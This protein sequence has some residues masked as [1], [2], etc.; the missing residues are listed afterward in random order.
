MN[1]CL[2]L[3]LVLL[4]FSFFFVSST[5]SINSLN[6]TRTPCQLDESQSHLQKVFDKID[7]AVNNGQGYKNYLNPD[8]FP[9]GAILAWSESYL[10]Q[11]YAEMFRA[12]GNKRYLDK[13]YDHIESVMKNRDDLRK[14][15]DYKGDLVPAWGTNRFTKEGKWKHFVVHTGMITF[16]MLE[17]V[18]LVREHRIERLSDK[19]DI[20]LA[21]VR[22]AVDY[23]D[24]Q[25]IIQK[26]GFGLYTFREDFYGRQN[27]VL[28]LSQQAAMGRALLLLSKLTG[29]EKYNKKVQDIT[30][31]IK[32][33][34]REDDHG[35]YVWGIGI[36]S[37]PNENR[38]ADIS[39][40]AITVH[41]IT[42]VSDSGLVFD[43]K[44]I[45]KVVTTMKRLLMEKRVPRYIDG[46]GDYICEVTAGQY[47]FLTKYDPI[48][49]HRCHSL[50]FDLY[51]VD[52][53]AKY[54]QED[55]WG[56]VMLGIA[57]L[58]RYAE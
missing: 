16:P 33:S 52:L 46:T 34:L 51:K 42:L 23:H 36:T 22:E 41:F 2:P 35:G 18:Q 3:I 9:T 27:Y 39:H 12:T 25:W 5:I 53:T 54:F 31:T 38:I 28:P 13:L 49:W 6:S 50:L 15:L 56:T 45:E 37:F 29:D 10:M 7:F 19:A 30:S 44:D 47:A 1:R 55:W 58:A 21:C 20:V 4:F 32:T 43:L 26:A 24:D 40:S 48:I 11:S 57:R 17:F 8:G 14:Q